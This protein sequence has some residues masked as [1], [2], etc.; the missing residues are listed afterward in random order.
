MTADERRTADL[1]ERDARA[2]ALAMSCVAAA[3]DVLHVRLD[4]RTHDV[5]LLAAQLV[6]SRIYI[7]DAEIRALREERDRYRHLANE[8]LNLVPPPCFVVMKEEEPTT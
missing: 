8:A 5:T 7:E 3:A 2:R 1:M 4:Q 6:V